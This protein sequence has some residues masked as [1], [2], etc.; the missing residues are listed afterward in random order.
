[1]LYRF[2]RSVQA[3]ALLAAAVAL[4]ATGPEVAEAEKSPL[5]TCT[6]AAWANYNECLMESD[7]WFHR[8]GCDFDFMMSYERCQ[9]LFWRDTLGT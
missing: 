5:R 9:I 1:M 8:Q 4:V 7:S 6:D 2:R 3:L